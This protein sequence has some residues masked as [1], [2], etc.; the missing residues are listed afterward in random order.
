[1]SV[2]EFFKNTYLLHFSKPAENRPVYRTLLNQKPT[3]IVELGLGDGQRTIQMLQKA[4]RLSPEATIKYTGID[5]FEARSPEQGP[6]MSLKDA[7]RTLK[8]PNVKIQLV[9][10]DPFSALARMANTLPD[11]DLLIISKCQDSASLE[12]AWFYVPRMLHSQS[13]ILHEKADGSGFREITCE[14]LPAAKT[15]RRAA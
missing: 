1:M 3:R 11:T 6:G 14:E 7:H 8:M 9:P 4:S 10:G 13:V 2:I 5:L 12:R 15:E